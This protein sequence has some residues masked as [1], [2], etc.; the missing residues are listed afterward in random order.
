MRS[1][2][3]GSQRQ[4]ALLGKA[5]LGKGRNPHR[6]EGKEKARLEKWEESVQ[7]LRQVKTEPEGEA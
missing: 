2:S 6:I 3:E 5:M 1:E 4:R 7:K